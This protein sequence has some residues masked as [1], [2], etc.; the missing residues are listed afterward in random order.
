MSVIKYSIGLNPINKKSKS[1]YLWRDDGKTLSIVARFSNKEKML[2]FA[3]EF[4]FPLSE[5][6]KNFLNNKQENE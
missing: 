2:L 5:N 3:K 4:E 1:V 6:V